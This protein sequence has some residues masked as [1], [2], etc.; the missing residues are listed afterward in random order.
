[1]KI[2]YAQLLNLREEIIR[3][4]WTDNSNPEHRLQVRLAIQAT[5]QP[6]DYVLKAD[7]PAR[8]LALGLALFTYD[9]EGL[10]YNGIKSEILARCEYLKRI[11][12]VH[13]FKHKDGQADMT[14][15]KKRAEHKSGCG[16]WLNSRVTT[17]LD[18]IR[19]EYEQTGEYIVW[20][21]DHLPIPGRKNDNEIHI[22]IACTW[23][24]FFKYLDT[25]SAGYRT[26]FKYNVSKSQQEGR[27]VWEMNTL[28]S[29]KKKI[30]FLENAEF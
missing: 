24:Q 1:M 30:E 20:D 14:Y 17:D 5:F 3:R 25:Y 12:V 10:G 8:K 21:Y 9:R 28:R 29:S 23:R 15:N 2:E 19:M 18:Q 22:H 4:G 13:W 26:F 11:P 7:E 16:A 6:G 27:A